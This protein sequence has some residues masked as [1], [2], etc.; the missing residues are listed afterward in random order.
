MTKEEKIYLHLTCTKK[1]L[2]SLK[3]PT[4]SEFSRSSPQIGE[5][6]SRL[7]ATQNIT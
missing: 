7:K 6:A 2:A 1:I 4:G 5:L 3:I